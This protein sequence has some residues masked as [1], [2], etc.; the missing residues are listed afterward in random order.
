[1]EDVTT[2]EDAAAK[3]QAAF[4]AGDFMTATVY[5]RRAQGIVGD[6]GRVVQMGDGALQFVPKE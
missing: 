5:L 3:S 4:K 2:F 6:K 1:M